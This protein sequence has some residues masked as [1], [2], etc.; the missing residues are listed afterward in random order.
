MTTTAPRVSLCMPVYN[1]ENYIA[2]ALDSIA[3]QGFED[4]EL[5]VTD[6]ASSDRTGEIVQ[7]RAARDPRIRYVRNRENLGAAPNYNLGYELSRGEYLKW[8][9]HDDMISANFLELMVALLDRDPSTS[10]AF[11]QT[12]CIDSQ[13]QKIPG[14]GYHTPPIEEPDA[15]ARFYAGMRQTGSCYPIFGLFRKAALDRSMLHLSYYGSDKALLAEMLLLGK[16]RIDEDA[17]YY[18]REHPRQSVRMTNRSQR[19]LWQSGKSGRLAS[20][21]RIQLFRHLFQIAGRHKDLAAPGKAR[22]A[23]LRYMREPV[24]MG[25]IVTDLVGLASPGAASFLRRS[26]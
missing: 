20:A 5:I 6:N 13:D 3:E 10:V 2:Q 14:T 25:R 9:A 18:N 12:I 26:T 8:F 1:G 23:V 4:Y 17:I 24:Q 19:S 16:L 22:A 7:A 21:E 15:V 11:G